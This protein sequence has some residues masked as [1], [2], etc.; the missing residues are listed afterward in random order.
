[1]GV[2]AGNKLIDTS[3]PS[4]DVRLEIS[5]LSFGAS[6]GPNWSIKNDRFDI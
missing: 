6:N 5:I 4:S 3:F 2:V 1:M